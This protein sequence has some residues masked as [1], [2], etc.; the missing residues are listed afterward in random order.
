MIS[1]LLQNAIFMTVFT[2]PSTGSRFGLWCR[3]TLCL[4]WESYETYKW[5]LWAKCIVFQ[6]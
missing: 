4:E 5:N 1:P 3:S 6:H 2:D